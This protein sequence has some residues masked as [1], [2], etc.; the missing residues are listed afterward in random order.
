MTHQN[1]NIYELKAVLVANPESPL[2]FSLGEQTIHPGYHVTEIKHAAI[3]SL[4]C[5]NGKD[6]WDEIVVQLLDG[7]PNFKGGHM[8]CA[9]FVEIVSKAVESTP[10]DESTLTFIEFSPDNSGLRKLAISAIEPREDR[11]VIWLSNP[12]AVCKPFQRALAG[13]SLSTRDACC[14]I[15]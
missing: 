10:Y 6:Q 2:V 8:N 4:D 11:V 9:K 5:G 14:G 3:N 7:N 13:G 12:P 1:I 15:A